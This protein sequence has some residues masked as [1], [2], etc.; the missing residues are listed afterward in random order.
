MIENPMTAIADE[1]P[2]EIKLIPAD[3]SWAFFRMHVRHREIVLPQ[4]NLWL[5]QHK[6]AASQLELIS[7]DDL[8]EEIK[9]R[10]KSFFLVAR[11]HDSKDF[12][13][14]VNSGGG[15]ITDLVGMVEIGKSELIALD[16]SE[17]PKQ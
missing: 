16:K 14:R 11:T 12:A 10:H 2:D 3:P 17:P 5:K 8:V 7:T 6:E 9:R 13:W 1:H 4:L 15:P